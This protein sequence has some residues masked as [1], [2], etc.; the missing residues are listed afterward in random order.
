MK[1]KYFFLLAALLLANCIPVDAS[2]RVAEADSA[3]NAGEYKRA[4]DLY[5]EIAGTEGTSVALLYNLGNAYYQEG[6]YGNAMVCYQRARRLDPSND[7]VNANLR[8]LSGRVEDANKA[9]QKGKRFKTGMDEPSFFQMVQKSVAQDISTDLWATLAAVA[10]VLF[11][12][13]LALYIFSRNVAFRKTGFFGGI[14]LFASGMV[15]LLFAFMG[16][17]ARDSDSEGVVLAFKSVLLTEPGKTENSER[18]PVLTKGTVVRV[19]SE[20]VD[21]EG[22]VTW[23]K[24]RLNSDYIGWVAASD[25]ERI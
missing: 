14:V 4:I 1:I 9:E 22:N 10:F 8:Y 7:K 18:G 21:A 16:A 5:K 25:L 6:D 12:G 11:V 17:H 20:E 13:F 15:F 24:I 2:E 19:L 23:Y 3:Y